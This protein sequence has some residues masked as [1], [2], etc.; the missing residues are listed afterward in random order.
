MICC[1][2]L[3]RCCQVFVLG[4]QFHVRVE[5]WKVWLGLLRTNNVTLT[6]LTLGDV[7]S[8]AECLPVWRAELWKVG[9]VAA[10]ATEEVSRVLLRE[11]QTVHITEGTS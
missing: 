1:S 6:L 4:N 5:R 3:F 10:A 9:K 7:E 11:L 8:C 2:Q